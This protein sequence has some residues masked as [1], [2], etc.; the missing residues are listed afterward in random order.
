M[1]TT[2]TRLLHRERGGAYASRRFVRS[3]AH[4][5]GVEACAYVLYSTGVKAK[6]VCN[7]H[8]FA[9]FPGDNWRSA[10]LKGPN[11]A[12]PSLETSA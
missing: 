12:H 2:L 7:T 10:R 5:V 3:R 8:L 9:P 11:R 6:M 4:S 1:A